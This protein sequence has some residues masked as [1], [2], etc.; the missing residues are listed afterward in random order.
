MTM[1]RPGGSQQIVAG[2]PPM[3]MLDVTPAPEAEPVHHVRDEPEA[4]VG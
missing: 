3:P 2:A 1:V 4:D